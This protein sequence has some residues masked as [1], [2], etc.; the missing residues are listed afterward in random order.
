MYS[1]TPSNIERARREFGGALEIVGRPG[2]YRA[3]QVT[4]LYVDDDYDCKRV[5]APSN[6]P[7]GLVAEFEKSSLAIAEALELNGVM[8]VEAILSRGELKI[9]EIDARLPSQTPTAVYWSTGS[10]MVQLLGDLFLNRKTRIQ[11]RFSN[12]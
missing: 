3:L 7:P 8:D 10:N 11:G 5:V 2:S 9:L 6:L 1:R 4:D 12:T